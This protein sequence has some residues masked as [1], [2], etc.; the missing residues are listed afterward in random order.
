MLT[1]SDSQG[2]EVSKIIRECSNNKIKTVGCVMLNATTKQVFYY[3]LNADKGHVVIISR[4]NYLQK[5]N[6][7]EI[8][9]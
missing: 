4:T 8:Y 9:S 6:T 5:N 2:R 7:E 1:Y 3:A